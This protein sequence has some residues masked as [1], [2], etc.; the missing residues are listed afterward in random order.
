MFHKNFIFSPRVCGRERERELRTCFM[1]ETCGQRVPARWVKLPSYLKKSGGKRNNDTA[2]DKS[3]SNIHTI[4]LSSISNC[5]GLITY[6]ATKW[7]GSNKTC[8][9]P[10]F[11]T[12]KSL[13]SRLKL[14]SPPL[15]MGEFLSV[16]WNSREKGLP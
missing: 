15:L 2:R 1:E 13:S 9:A 3:I 16:S 14:R 4:S 10:R 5:V 6:N 8:M 7:R 11:E 12:H